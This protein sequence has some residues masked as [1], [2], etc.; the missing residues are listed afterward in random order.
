MGFSRC[1]TS[2]RLTCGQTDLVRRT[3]RFLK[4]EENLHRREGVEREGRRM[5]EVET[6]LALVLEADLADVH[7]AVLFEVGPWRVDDG[8]V[9]L[10]VA[11]D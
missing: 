6:Y 3:G 5:K 10:F 1:G 4:Y 11:C 8:D 7:A 2:T 9:V